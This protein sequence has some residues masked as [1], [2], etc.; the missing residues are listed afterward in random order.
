MAKQPISQLFSNDALTAM[1]EAWGIHDCGFRADRSSQEPGQ[2]ASPPQTPPSRA[3]Q[4]PG[5]A[6]R[7]PAGS[8]VPNPPASWP[9]AERRRP[10]SQQLAKR[11]RSPHAATSPLTSF[12][13]PPPP[14]RASGSA[15]EPS[16]AC[17]HSSPT[18]WADS[19][20]ARLLMVWFGGVQPRLL[21]VFSLSA[22]GF[23]T[24][25][26]FLE[27]IINQT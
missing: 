6:H 1:R 23:A 27:G 14:S 26:V 12:P 20:V 8:P 25:W 2:P 24:H 3:L 13:F 22:V 5:C 19:M 15:L 11:L 7:I 18:L 4:I 10:A 9:G 21:R 17:G 16:R